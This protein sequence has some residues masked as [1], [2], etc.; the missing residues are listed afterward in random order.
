MEDLMYVLAMNRLRA[1]YTEINPGVGPY[2]MSSV[3]DDLDGSRR[4][5]DFLCVRRSFSQVAGSSMMFIVAG[6]AAALNAP[7]AVVIVAGGFCGVAY[8][9]A[10]IMLNARRYFGFW[11]QYV[12]YSPSQEDVKPG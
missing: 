11:R 7:V 6:L 3:H 2:L 9:V 5:Y 4:T 1:A 8:L 12:P 10:S